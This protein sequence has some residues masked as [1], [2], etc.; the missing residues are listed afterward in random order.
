[1]NKEEFLSKVDSEM[2]TVKKRIESLNEKMD[3]ASSDLKADYKVQIAELESTIN[4]LNLQFEELKDA[5]E[6]QW[7]ET[8][9]AISSK[10]TEIGK[11]LED[12]LS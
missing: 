9:D 1:M 6:A 11:K 8:Y 10:T 2:D 5:A 12:W 4:G 3:Q 7:E